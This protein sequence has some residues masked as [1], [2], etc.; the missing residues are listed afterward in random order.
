[1]FNY[2]IISCSHTHSFDYAIRMVVDELNEK[3]QG[4]WQPCGGIDF[5]KDGIEYRVSQAIVREV[6]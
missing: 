1:M 6:K 4:G 2:D 3:I 5:I